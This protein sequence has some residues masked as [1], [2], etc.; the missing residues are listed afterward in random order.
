MELFIPI[1]EL[2]TDKVQQL[3]DDESKH[4][5]AEIF[6]CLD[7]KTFVL[8]ECVDIISLLTRYKLYKK[9]TCR[10]ILKC[11]MKIKRKCLRN[12]KFVMHMFTHTFKYLILFFIYFDAK[13]EIDDSL[14]FRLNVPK[15][16]KSLNKCMLTLTDSVNNNNIKPKILS[17]LENI[18]LNNIEIIPELSYFKNNTFI[19]NFIIDEINHGYPVRILIQILNNLSRYSIF[20]NIDINIPNNFDISNIEENSKILS[21]EIK[22][23]INNEICNVLNNYDKYYGTYNIL[24]MIKQLYLRNDIFL[25][26]NYEKCK[27]FKTYISHSLFDS[28]L[29]DLQ[30]ET[31]LEESFFTEP[32]ITY[33]NRI[34]FNKF[35]FHI[36][37]IEVIISDLMMTIDIYGN[38]KTFRIKTCI[39]IGKILS[40]YMNYCDKNFD[41]MDNDSVILESDHYIRL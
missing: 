32:I 35:E 28:V 17:K 13:N 16:L 15:T 30:F 18:N 39:E 23:S 10:N 36:N 41:E 21:D 7:R 9:K 12:E 38:I 3:T 25:L 22:T 14:D 40:H 2:V 27:L 5:C 20:K 29:G 6:N 37:F 26:L 34:D 19:K 4:I 33:T 11:F 8:H 24:D 31:Q 1:T